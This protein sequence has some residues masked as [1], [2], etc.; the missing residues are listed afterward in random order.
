MGVVDAV[1][2]GQN[3][4]KRHPEGTFRHQP[5]AHSKIYIIQWDMPYRVALT[6]HRHSYEMSP[7]EMETCFEWGKCDRKA[8]A[9]WQNNKLTK[10]EEDMSYR[11]ALTTH[12]H[13]YEKCNKKNHLK[14]WQCA[15]SEEIA[16][17]KRDEKQWQYGKMDKHAKSAQV[18]YI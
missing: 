12:R 5:N 14:R 3:I 4:T 15:L 10:S 7:E 16:T 8:M 2:Q 6:T 18:P 9:T 17:K 13:S 1:I 11:A